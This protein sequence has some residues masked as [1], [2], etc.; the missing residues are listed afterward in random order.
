ERKADVVAH[1]LERRVR[2][3]MLNVAPGSGVEVVDAEHFVAALQQPL[4]E[5]RADETGSAGDENTTVREGW[6]ADSPCDA[7]AA[8]PSGH[9]LG[10]G[11]A[12][13]KD[14]F[15]NCVGS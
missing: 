6:H 11:R 3:Q 15:R 2:Q 14:L 8:T 9:P 7:A 12:L 10:Q 4:A 5:M 1:Q 13:G